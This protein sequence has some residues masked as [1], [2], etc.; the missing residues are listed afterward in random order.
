M[1]WI[2]NKYRS[3]DATRVAH[4]KLAELA[5]S[6]GSSGIGPGSPAPGGEDD[7]SPVTG[8]CHAGICGSRGLQCPRPPDPGVSPATVAKHYRSMPQLFRWLAD[9]GYYGLSPLERSA[10]PA[11]AEPPG[12]I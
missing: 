10:R 6:P 11:V 9:D 1:R 4:R 3:L 5:A 8:D 7:K 12:P 2:R